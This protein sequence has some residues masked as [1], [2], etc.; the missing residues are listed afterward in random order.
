MCGVIGARL[1]EDLAALDFLLVDAAEEGA[2]IVASA[3]LVEELVEHLDAGYDRGL[4]RLDADDLDRLVDLDDTALDAA[5]DDRATAGDGEN[6]LD[7]H[8]EGLVGD[9]LGIGEEGV[10][11]VQELLDALGGFG[12]VGLGEGLERG[13]P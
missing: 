4:G 8:Q 3:A 9:A 13:S 6:I 11:G 10:H 12:I 1:G 2:D 5:R 7:R